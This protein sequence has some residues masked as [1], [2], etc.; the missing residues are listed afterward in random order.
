MHDIL[1]LLKP[2]IWPITNR[3]ARKHNGSGLVKNCLL[4]AIGLSFWGIIFTVSIRVL[5]YFKGI[6]E[7]G[8]VLGY[9]LLSMILVVSFALLIFSSILTS[10][11]KLFL[12][13][14]LMLVHSL[15]ISSYKIFVARWIDSAVESAWMV[16]IFTLPIFLS[17]GIV[18]RAGAIFYISIP[19]TMIPLV[20]AASAISTVLV[21]A[22][23]M[24]IPAN[25]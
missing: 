23:V 6:E 20:V 11:S 22:A 10:L 3:K 18:F 1:T 15:P 19:L 8:N 14:D 16:I 5:S 13:R 21:M 24:V 4:G 9:K 7:I 17:Y 2:R 12:S 25:R